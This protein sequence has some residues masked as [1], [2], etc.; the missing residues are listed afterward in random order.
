MKLW[1]ILEMVKYKWYVIIIKIKNKFKDNLWNIGNSVMGYFVFRV[2]GLCVL[3]KYF[4]FRIVFYKGGV[5]NRK[6]KSL[7]FLIIVS[8]W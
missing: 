3:E 4:F 5:V 6:K 2:Y 8:C 1:N 7:S